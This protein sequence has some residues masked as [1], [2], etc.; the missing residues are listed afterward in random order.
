MIYYALLLP[1]NCLFSQ[2]SK[3][4]I[5][6]RGDV[7]NPRQ[8]SVEQ[9]KAEFSNQIQQVKFRDPLSS[10]KEK[11]GNGIPLYSLIKAAE[12]RKE[13]E[14]QWTRRDRGDAVTHSH[15]AF[16]VILEAKDS[17]HA[18]FSLAELMPHFRST[19]VFLLWD[20]D[21]ET[22]SGKDAPLRLAVANDRDPDRAIYGISSIT[23]VDGEKL[24]D[25]LKQ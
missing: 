16:F 3:P 19:E 2:E 23:L 6:I 12:P 9:L 20:K 14:T 22:L 11:T 1:L 15:M 13:K 21:G 5:S 25:Q 24:A 18:F 7:K 10:F 8:W 4:T 17:F